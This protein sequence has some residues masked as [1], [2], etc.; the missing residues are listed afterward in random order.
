[1]S[2]PHLNPPATLDPPTST[3]VTPPRAPSATRLAFLRIA[4]LL[5][6]LN[7]AH[8]SVAGAGGATVREYR[9]TFRTYPFSD[10]DPIPNG[11]RIYPYF[12]Y[13]GFTD[14]AEEREWTVIEL[15]NPWIRVTV[16]PE[17]GGKIWSAVEKSTGKGFLYGNQVVKFRDIA[18]R[19]PWTSGGIEANYGIIG[20]TPNCATPVDYRT[21]QHPDGSAS[22][23]IGVLDLLTRTPWRLEVT[24]PADKAYFTTASLW[25]NATPLEQPY[26]TWMNAGIKAAGN[27]QFVFPGTH[28]LDHDGRAKPWP[29]E[30]QTGRDLSFYENNNFGSYKSYHV[31]GRGADFFA[32]F[33]HDEDFGMGRFSR[34]DEKPGKKIWIWGLSREGMIWEKLLTDSDGQYVEVQSGRSFNQADRN[35]TQTPFKHR[36]FLPYG[37]DTWTE[38]WFPVKGTKGLVAVSPLGGLNVRLRDGRLE[39][40][41]SPLET[42]D[43]TLEVLDGERI[44]FTAA[45]SAKPLEPWTTTVPVSIPAERLRVRIGGN[46]LEWNGNPNAGELSRPLRAPA[47]F[48]WNS[49]YGLWLKGKQLLRQRAYAQARTALEA[50]LRQDPHYVPALGDLAL[51][52]LFAMDAQGAF[53]LARRALAIDTYDP[54]ANYYFGLA[55]RRL[56]RFD[57][58]RDGFELASQSVELRGAAWT[59]LAKLALRA[60]DFAR[61]GLD[62]GRSLDF[63]RRNLEARQLLA[64]V[65]RLQECRD[66]A[67]HALDELLALDPLNTFAGF[68]QALADGSETARRTFAASIRNELPQE[69]FL[70]LAAWY[71]DLGRAAEAAQV[72]ELAPQTAEVL[73]WRARLAPNQAA[74]TALLQQAEA[75]S[76]Q[77]VFPFRWESAEV[78]QWAASRSSSWR[79]RYYLGL[80]HWGAGNLDEARRRF[81][82]CGDQPDYAPFYAARALIFEDVSL[83]RS[84]ADLREAARRDPAQWRFGKMLIERQLGQGSSAIA[85]ETARRYCAQA[86]DNYILGMLHAKALLAEGQH[87]Q[88]AERLTR[89]QV[90]PYE[91]ATEGRR[92]YREALLMLTVESL[93]K[94]DHAAA[95][96]SIDAA[97]LWPENLGAGK[98]YPEA[99]DERL[100]DFLAAQALS[101]RGDSATANR[102]LRQ[103]TTFDTRGGGADRLIHALALKQMGRAAEG[104]QFLDDWCARE[105]ANVL[106]AWAAQ[107]YD[108]PA[109]PPP[110][111]A[112]DELRVLAAWLRT[113][114]Q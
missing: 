35:S 36:G 66:E 21:R 90:L 7:A 30:P 25:H 67:G 29:I 87:Q 95:L 17:I 27:L 38:Y 18:L 76:P 65:L 72:L 85:L 62:A 2:S 41:F 6:A 24:V 112:N 105:P 4:V 111:A 50:C 86:P 8:P 104:R 70:E 94:G 93:R 78:L 1:M 31:L 22:V 54:A 60:G 96:R 20:H 110:H 83:E 80:V 97:R 55:A 109:T 107:A 37:T 52:H 12:R 13:D 74:A 106:A 64:L 61:A 48:D 49:V 89:L 40:L 42:V 23:V 101:R 68:E 82:E 43:D 98:P 33:W 99:L 51:L 34:R 79:P 91:G 69:L 15:E 88:A 100:E 46:R 77:R 114:P 28:H 75:A 108:G 53:D 32:A 58:A 26:Y 44:V 113:A 84:L 14:R 102:L 63:N 11:G 3:A 45:V 56:G 71:H 5:L 57:D 59:E 10:P 19:G 16:L 81:D 9:K 47:D 92:L 103:I 73:Y 39:I